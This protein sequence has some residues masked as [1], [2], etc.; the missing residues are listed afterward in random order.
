MCCRAR[1]GSVVLATKHASPWHRLSFPHTSLTQRS[2]Q[3]VC[4]QGCFQWP[5]WKALYQTLWISLWKGLLVARSQCLPLNFPCPLQAGVRIT[6]LCSLLVSRNLGKSELE[7]FTA[8]AVLRASS[9][10]LGEIWKVGWASRTFILS[11]LSTESAGPEHQSASY[12]PFAVLS[13]VHRDASP[14]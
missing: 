8:N 10:K 12:P 2:P 6:F 4:L 1:S 5:G 14:R 9:E 11:E 13:E 3:A 7:D